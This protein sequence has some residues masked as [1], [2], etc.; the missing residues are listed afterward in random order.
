MA[1]AWFQML[2]KWGTDRMSDEMIMALT[3][4]AEIFFTGVILG[5]AAGYWL[6]RKD[7][8]DER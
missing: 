5:I 3:I 1:A 4:C 8:S 6:G 2:Q 7:V